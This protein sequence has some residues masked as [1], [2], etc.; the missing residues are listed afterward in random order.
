MVETPALPVTQLSNR[1]SSLA[2]VDGREL[3]FSQVAEAL[4]AGSKRGP[5]SFF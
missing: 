4:L 1:Q 3:S 5:S 2:V